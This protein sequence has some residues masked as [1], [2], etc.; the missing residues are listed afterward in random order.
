[1]PS[2]YK[3]IT[4]HNEKQLG[5]DTASRK[6]Q[7]S[8]YSDSTHFVYE[9][10]Q[11][12]DD[13]GATEVCFK[14]S[15]NEIVIEHNGEPFT[16]KNVE[17]ITYFG[18][19]TSRDDLVKTGRF[20]VGFKSVFAF[21]AKPVIISGNEHFQIYGLYRI[22]EYPYPD[23]FSRSRTRIVLP[24][25]HE[26]E[27]P[28]FVEKLIR[29]EEAY[30][31]ISECLAILDMNTLLFTRNIQEIRLE[32]NNRS[33]YYR[34]EDKTDNNVRFTTITDGRQENKYVVFSKVPKWE[35]QAYK[36]VEIAFTADMQDQLSP[37]DDDSLYVLF[38]TAEK[39]GLKFMLNGP[40]RTNPARE[41]I[42]KT[43]D[44][45][46][47]LMKVTCELLKESLPYLRDRNLL[48]VEF[49]LILPNEED[50]LPDFYTPLR[51]TIISEFRNKKLTPTKRGDYA[52]ASRLYRDRS[53]RGLSD[54]I[55]DTDLATLVGQDTTL[56]LWVANTPQLVQK[57]NERGQFVQDSNAQ[58]RNK[59]I[60]DFLSMLDI[61]EW[62]TED[63]IEAL[64]F[65]SNLL[66]KWLKEKSDAWHQRFYTLLDDFISSAFTRSYIEGE[67]YRI[68]LEQL[69]IVRCSDGIHRSG[70]ECH[71]LNDDAESDVDLFS[72]TIELEEEIQLQI[73]EEDEHEENFYYVAKGIYSSGRNRDEKAKKFLETIGVRE[74]DETE[75]IKMILKQRYTRGSIKPREADLERF[76][77]LVEVDPSKAKLFTSYP[78]F[79]IDKDLDNKNWW[80]SPR[81]IFLDSPYL[82]TGLT[83]YYKAI[84]EK[85]NHFR[86]ALSP[87]YAK[88]GIDP[89]RL[90][91]FAEAVDA[92]TKLQISEHEISLDHP[93]RRWLMSAPGTW[94]TDTGRNKD[95]SIPEFEALFYEPSIDKAKL[96]WRTMRSA[97]EHYLKARFRWNQSNELH[98]T[99]S[100]L[101]HN[102]K[103]TEWV[104]QKDGDSISFVLP[105]KAS[106]ERLP[107]GFP[108]ETEQKW[109]QAI[110]FG[111]IARE[112]KAEYIQQNRRAQEMGFNSGAEAETMVE[113]AQAWR[114][115][116][117]SPEEMRDRISADKR[118]AERLTIE[119]SDAEE[120][121][122]E[123]RAR[124]IR[125]TRS[126][127]D[128][129][130]HLRQQYT[131]FNNMECQMCRQEMP[132]KKR[133]SDDDY[134]EAVEAFGKDHFPKE[135]EAQHLALCPECAAK[136]KE[137]VKKDKVA[138][139][140]LYNLL[141]DLDE[142]EVYLELRDFVIRIWFDKKHWHDLKTVLHYY[143]NVYEAENST[144]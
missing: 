110:E 54:L 124:S 10:L 75:R 79:Q 2:D 68:V 31:Q 119:L 137:Y 30:T 47:H 62:K 50:T 116:G 88:S 7:V 96:I 122:Y 66:M 107:E 106:V 14:L 69:P 95:Y 99:H 117:K 32:I 129:H 3:A 61:T 12:A 87:K 5:E 97:P 44:F 29:R 34:R 89:K 23:G 40:Y 59:R 115:Q 38:K 21:T 70:R 142:P 53:G 56:S 86:R 92:Q 141:K 144:D 105:R 64:K 13:H 114:L 111:E 121:Q 27:Q 52:A 35:N 83:A 135:H 16:E 91:K 63:L 15:K 104:P 94:L 33:A 11:N 109:L 131:K 73:Q 138:R 25:N 57:R 58:R 100:S 81:Q 51:D 125:S 78:I 82:D 143:A 140:S 1:M 133:N 4:A 128:P 127:I 36:A 113:I 28:D 134:F 46:L 39:T 120:K 24:F 20:G 19:S 112:Q 77:K 74:V 84:E 60:G 45:N 85:S 90:G 42:S 17:A 136:Y 65:R 18:K 103:E 132:F 9:I 22:R 118:R 8:M 48:T 130:T 123:I 126:T 93:E 55:Q 71:F 101:V 43:D 67:Q 102:L 98:E 37:I 72:G 49:L 139:K 80:A 108:Y 26:S 76:I 6:T 41:T